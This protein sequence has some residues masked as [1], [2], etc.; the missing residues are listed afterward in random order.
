MD[1]TEKFSG[2]AKDYAAGRPGYAP[3]FIEYLYDRFADLPQAAVADVGCGTGK[4]AALLLARGTT[5]YGV[6]PNADM[7]VVCAEELRDFANFHLVT[8]DAENTTLAPASVDYV[9]VAQAFHWF[10]ADR[11]AAECR[12]I[13]RKD[14]KAVLLWNSR[15][16]ESTFKKALSRVLAAHCP[17]YHGF[18]NGLARDD[19]RIVRFFGGR[20]ERVAFDHP[21]RMNRERFMARCFSAS[22][23]LRAEDAGFDAYTAALGHLFDAFAENGVVTIPNHTVAY[24][25][26]VPDADTAGKD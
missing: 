20:Y 12:R 9:T 18:N 3:A 23:S 24:I 14:G 5:V 13:L 19:A 15:D 8:G 21:L 11:F 17:D 2:R 1:A 22:Y 25:G 6:E 16:P 10:D 26:G 7:R 4:F